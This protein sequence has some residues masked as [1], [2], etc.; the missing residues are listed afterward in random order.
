MEISK[1]NFWNF[2]LGASYNFLSFSQLI[3]KLLSTFLDFWMSKFIVLLL[4]FESFLIWC[5]ELEIFKWKDYVRDGSVCCF[6]WARLDCNFNLN[7]IQFN[8][9][10]WTLI[11]EFKLE[12]EFCN[13]NLNLNWKK[14]MS[15][16]VLEPCSTSL[17]KSC[18]LTTR[19]HSPYQIVMKIK[20]IN[21]VWNFLNSEPP[22]YSILE[23]WVV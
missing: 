23:L 18:L 13:F 8:L 20:N 5:L 6:M 3:I 19:P 11:F 14:T 22:I 16:L 15:S 17:Y 1:K 9:N 21:L 2:H 4:C 10:F 12:L 7:S